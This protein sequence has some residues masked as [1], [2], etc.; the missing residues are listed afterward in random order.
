MLEVSNA[1]AFQERRFTCAKIAALKSLMSLTLRGYLDY[2]LEGLPSSVR[3]LTLAFGPQEVP[4]SSRDISVVPSLP[5]HRHSLEKLSIETDGTVGLPMDQV[6]NC[7]LEV[8]VYAKFV[9]VGVPV[10]DES[11]ITYFERPYREGAYVSRVGILYHCL[12]RLNRVGRSMTFY[13]GSA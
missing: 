4:L 7:C 3:L 9:L 5:K 11:L 10:A 12:H 8:D 13:L 2:D 6:W 1:N